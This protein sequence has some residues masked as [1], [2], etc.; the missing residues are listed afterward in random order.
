M[1][2]ALWPLAFIVIASLAAWCW[3][4]W[5]DRQT[6]PLADLEQLRVAAARAVRTTESAAE[7]FRAKLSELEGLEQRINT[8]ERQVAEFDGRL[9]VIDN[10]TAKVPP[11]W[12]GG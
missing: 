12:A 10:R 8:V 7:G 1:I 4:Q 5:L 2:D 3:L 9:L 11:R 6:G